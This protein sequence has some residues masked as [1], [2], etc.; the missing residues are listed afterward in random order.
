M[1]APKQTVLTSRS[2]RAATRF[3]PGIPGFSIVRQAEA[4]GAAH[5]RAP[6]VAVACSCK[7]SA[8]CPVIHVDMTC[9]E[10]EIALLCAPRTYS[11]VLRVHLIQCAHCRHFAEDQLRLDSA[12]ES[13]VLAL[14]QLCRISPHQALEHRFLVIK[15]A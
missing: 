6:R 10:I 5:T 1:P 3:T 2:L 12:I 7:L 14:V 15:H 9:G 13:A 4:R 11:E 8:C